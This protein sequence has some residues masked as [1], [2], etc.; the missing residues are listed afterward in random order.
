VGLAAAHSEEED[1]DEIFT[2]DVPLLHNRVLLEIAI[3][4]FCLPFLTEP[5]FILDRFF[6]GFPFILIRN[7]S[8][9]FF[10]PSYKVFSLPSSKTYLHSLHIHT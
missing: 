4:H 5:S 7:Q 1:V 10:T 8:L 3:E 9:L 2:L 6:H